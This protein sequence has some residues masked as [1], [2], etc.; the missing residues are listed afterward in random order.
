MIPQEFDEKEKRGQQLLAAPIDNDA[1]FPRCL[2]AAD[3]Y[4]SERWISQRRP[5]PSGIF[6]SFCGS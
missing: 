1:S 4:S 3:K 6:V 2:L 5:T